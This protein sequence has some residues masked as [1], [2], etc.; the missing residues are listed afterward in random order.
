MDCVN[1]E[2]YLMWKNQ[3]FEAE[4]ITGDPVIGGIEDAVM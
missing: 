4:S 2:G 1:L 3:K